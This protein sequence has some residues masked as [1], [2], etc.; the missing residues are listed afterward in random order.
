[1][2]VF[3]KMMMAR[4]ASRMKTMAV[5]ETKSM[6][7][8]CRRCRRLLGGQN[9]HQLVDALNATA[10]SLVERPVVPVARV[11]PGA[12]QF[13]LADA[14]R[15][16]VVDRDGDLANELIDGDFLRAKCLQHRVPEQREQ[17]ERERGEQEPLHPHL[18]V[19]AEKLQR[20]DQKCGQ[21]EEDQ[22]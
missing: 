16:N 2:A 20:P 5:P 6:V 14:A 11:P 18:R 7:V 13:G 12:A 1:M 19:D 21:S 3:A 10:L 9:E 17:H 4:I 8:L 22:V 15:R